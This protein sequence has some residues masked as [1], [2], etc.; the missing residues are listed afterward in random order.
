[1]ASFLISKN[2]RRNCLDIFRKVTPPLT[3]AR[4]VGLLFLVS[5]LSAQVSEPGLSYGFPQDWSHSHVIFHP[6]SSWEEV[7]ALGTEP[8]VTH[9]ALR[10]LQTYLHPTNAAPQSA[11]DA[12]IQPTETHRDWSVS[13]GTGRVPAGMSPAKYTFD[14]TTAKCTDWAV[15]GLNV[16]GTTGGQGNMVAYKNL[17]SG[18]S[19]LCGSSGPTTQFSYNITTVTNGRVLTSPVISLDGKK[20]AFVESGNTATVFHVLTWKSGAGNGTSSTNSAFPGVGNSATMVS[21]TLTSTATDTR[22]SPWI[23]YIGDI[24][25]VGANTGRVYKIT[26]VFNGTPTLAGAPWPVLLRNAANLTAPVQDNV[27]HN[28]FVG[29]QLGTLYSVNSSTGTVASAQIGLTTGTNPAIRD[30][31]IVDSQNGGVFVQSANDGTSAVIV[32]L[33]TTNL[34]QLQKVRLGRGSSTGT[35]VNMYNGAFNNAY[36]TLPSSGTMFV[37]GTGAADTTPWGYTLGFTGT[38]LK[39]TPISQTQLVN[40]TASRCSEI[41][42]FFNPNIS[43]GT[44]YFF[45]GLTTGCIPASGAGCVMSRPSPGSV[46]TVS[47]TGGTSAI[48]VDNYSTAGQA[49]SIYFTNLGGNPAQAVK[50]TQNGLQ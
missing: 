27:T 34:A 3:A 19:G 8:R 6:F 5:A 11:D 26:G 14:P 15:F 16:A 50:L 31:P 4:V 25:Y 41:T 49:S 12:E 9:Q 37:C 43:G 13:L 36:Y 48:I 21:I 10:R 35:T 23:D 1:M 32:Q 20:I 42:E 33:K 28:I 44:D 29:D 38:T 22:S 24:A 45:L 30:A 39:S 47:E 2:G 18:T 17:Y 40:S 7:Q 46:L